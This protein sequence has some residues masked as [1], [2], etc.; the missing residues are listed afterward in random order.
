MPSLKI[1]SMPRVFTDFFAKRFPTLTHLAYYI[2]PEETLVL[3]KE[4]KPELLEELEI[5]AQMGCFM[6]GSGIYPMSKLAGMLKDSNLEFEKLKG[7]GSELSG[8]T[9]YKG[10]VQGPVCLVLS[11]ADMAKV[12]KGDIL[13]TPMTNPDMVPVMKIAG[14]VVTNEGGL[15]C[16]AAIA[17]R[18]LQVP[19]VVGT[20]FATEVLKDGDMVEVDAGKGVVSKLP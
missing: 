1:G 17:S 14:A 15:T 11:K 5:R 6:F 4:L 20:K 12:I 18:E 3:D 9:A 19:C 2:S 7:D 16:H 8:Q 13:V 10:K